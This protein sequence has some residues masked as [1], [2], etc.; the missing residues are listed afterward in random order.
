MT[1]PPVP[2]SARSTASQPPPPARRRKRWR[3]RAGRTACGL[4]VLVLLTS[5][6]QAFASGRDARRFPPPGEL[7]DIG[8]HRMHLHC[9]GRGS[10][11]VLLDHASGSLSAQWGLVQPSVAAVTRTCSYDRSGYGWS[12]ES[13]NGADAATQADELTALLEAAGETGP[14]L[15]VGHS[16]GTFVGAIFASEHPH[17]TA[18]LVMVEPGYVWGTPGMPAELDSDVRRQEGWL[19]DINLLLTRSGL[20]R[21]LAPVV[22]GGNDLPTEQQEPFD[23]L[24]LTTRQFAT[25]RAEIDAGEAT[26]AAVLAARREL[27]T[28]PLIVLSAE[29]PRNDRM[30]QEMRAT[31]EHIAAASTRGVHIDVDDTDHMGI[32]L[33]RR[34][35]ALVTGHVLAL[36]EDVRG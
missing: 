17:E 3:R 12:E 30:G 27:T 21:F 25:F 29:P 2:P 11:T 31:H 14:Y 5:A 26:S 8:S 32:V 36:L 10:P 35:A 6:Y 22:M 24:T 34:A 23:A 16:S 18:G 28:T 13:P 7:I 4:L 15:H 19:A 9:T 20:G 1:A 33:E